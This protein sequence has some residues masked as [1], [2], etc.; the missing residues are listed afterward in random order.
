MKAIKVWFDEKYIYVSTTLNETG[1][2]PLDWFPK[3]K[4]ANA[5]Q[6]SQYDLWTNGEWIHWE[7][8]GEDLGVEGFFKFEKTSV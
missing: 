7:E 1:K 8:I 4:N 5:I 2:M 6:R 3:L